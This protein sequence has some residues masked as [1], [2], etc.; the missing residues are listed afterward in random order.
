MKP[1]LR[2]L[3][4]L[5]IVTALSFAPMAQAADSGA[6][7]KKVLVF[8]KS[9]GFQ[10]DAIKETGQKDHGFA[11]AVL[12]EL[13]PQLNVEFIFSKDGSLFSAA[14]L[15][16]FDGFFFYT[17][18]DLT[19]PKS[20]PR[21]DGLP[22]MSAAGKAAFLAAVA[23]GKGFVGVHSA[24]DTFHSFGRNGPGPER[25][26]H[27]GDQ[28]DDYIKMLGGEFIR[29]GAEQTA[30]VIVADPKFPGAA[31]IPSGWTPH[32][33]WY[34]LKN[35]APD[36]HVILLQDTAGMR[37][38]EYQ[39]ANYPNTWARM[40][41]KGRV[42]YTSLGHREDIWRHPAYRALLAGAFEWTLGRVHT[43][44]TPNLATVAPEAN[45]LPKYVA[46]P[47]KAEKAPA[48]K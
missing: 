25:F 34:S 46:P 47:A 4:A 48:K 33:E 19:L 45:V 39:R 18:G 7:K 3:I 11:F 17:T 13:A 22:P 5:G 31:G 1:P 10:H 21:G 20:D 42:F 29:H 23:G 36:L 12:R 32:E 15:A 28:A 40:H 9:S 26:D 35:F 37:G 27:D 30:R 14:Y 24:S 41:G 8:T 16:P 43:D 38:A 2:W 44:V 6:P